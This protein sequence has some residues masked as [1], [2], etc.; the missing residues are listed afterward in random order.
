MLKMRSNMRLLVPN[1]AEGILNEEIEYLT[2]GA[3]G[4]SLDVVTTIA[5]RIDALP[6]VALWDRESFIGLAVPRAGEADC[7]VPIDSAQIDRINAAIVDGRVMTTREVEGE[8]SAAISCD[9]HGQLLPLGPITGRV[10]I[11]AR[12]QVGLS[13]SELLCEIYGLDRW[14]FETIGM[15]GFHRYRRGP[16]RAGV[17]RTERGDETSVGIV[18]FGAV[19][20][21]TD[22]LGKPVY[23]V[24]HN[25][26]MAA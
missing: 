25:R 9:F 26:R 10:S 2:P 6:L 14:V 4:Q 19:D 11:S 8:F 20:L 16:M 3:D 12:E 23:L 17:R 18:D 5:T 22:Q 21:A 24:S 7:G 1:E 15:D 13:F